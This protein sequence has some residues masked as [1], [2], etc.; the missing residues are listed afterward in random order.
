[1]TERIDRIECVD[2]NFCTIDEE[3]NFLCEKYKKQ[4]APFGRCIATK[5]HA[6][7]ER[8]RKIYLELYDK[9]SIPKIADKVGWGLDRLRYF[10]ERN[11]LPRPGKRIRTKKNKE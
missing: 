3:N 11:V 2:C 8:V 9:V 4:V 5:V 10:V 7:E 1:M 6:E